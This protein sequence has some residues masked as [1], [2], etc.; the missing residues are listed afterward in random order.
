MLMKIQKDVIETYEGKE[1]IF[2]YNN[3]EEAK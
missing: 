2:I 3:V 1:G